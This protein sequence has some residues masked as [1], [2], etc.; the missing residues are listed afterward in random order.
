MHNHVR[1]SSLPLSFF[2]SCWICFLISRITQADFT[3]Y[4]V[5]RYHPTKRFCQVNGILRLF[6]SW[7]R[8]LKVMFQCATFRLLMS[9]RLLVRRHRTFIVVSVV[10]RE[11][12]LLRE[13]FVV[14]TAFFKNPVA[15]FSNCSF[16]DVPYLELR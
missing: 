12:R 10:A 14:C 13:T 5:A 15:R 6:E 3:N 7:H 11:H 9:I 4:L 2:K 8:Y 16:K 1:P